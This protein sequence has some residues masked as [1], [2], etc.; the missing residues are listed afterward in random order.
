MNDGPLGGGEAQGAAIV[1]WSWRITL[2]LVVVLALGVAFSD[3]LGP[4]VAAISL[5]MFFGG[6]ALMGYAYFVGIGR[7][8]A[9]LVTVQ[10]LFLLQGSAPRGVRVGLLWSFTVQCAVAIIA[11]SL[12]LYTLIAFG[13]LA[14][15]IGL[16][17]AGLWGAKY[18][19]FERRDDARP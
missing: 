14:P 17:L 6:I 13:V 10:G 12:R 8:R 11:A 5:V 15:A 3:P 2:A 9:E 18:G 4:A 7:S 16:G 1:T 19:V